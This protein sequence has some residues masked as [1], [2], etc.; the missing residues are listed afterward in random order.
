MSNVLSVRRH[1]LEI[2]CMHKILDVHDVRQ[3]TPEYC[4]VPVTYA[5]L[6]PNVCNVHQ[7]MDNIS[8]TSAYVGAIHCVLSTPSDYCTYIFKTW[9]IY[10]S[11]IFA[12]NIDCG[13]NGLCKG[14]SNEYP[15]YMF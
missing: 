9:K 2:F 13:Y 6:M 15:Q 11:T 10:T 1:T 5:K 8:Y 3:P 12:Q 14:G 7:S 4:S